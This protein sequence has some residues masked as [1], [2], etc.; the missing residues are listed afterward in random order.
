MNIFKDRRKEKEERMGERDSLQLDGCQH[1]PFV[2]SEHDCSGPHYGAA[3][4]T[5]RPGWKRVNKKVT[6]A[7][8]PGWH[9]LTKTLLKNYGC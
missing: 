5:G 8:S 7:V 4:M 9:R 3:D 2:S 6:R 1:G